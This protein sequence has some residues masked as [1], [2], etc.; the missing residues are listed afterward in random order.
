[1]RLIL[2]YFLFYGIAQKAIAQN[3]LI[4]V[5]E[6]VKDIGL[7]ENIYKIKADYI[8]TNHQAKNLYLLRADAEKGITIRSS[9]KPSNQMIPF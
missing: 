4:T 8:I 3:N 7:Q 5:D 2:L 9:K 6:A 1:M